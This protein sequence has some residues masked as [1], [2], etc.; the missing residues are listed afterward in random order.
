MEQGSTDMYA[1]FNSKTKKLF[2]PIT[3]LLMFLRIKVESSAH[4][5]SISGFIVNENEKYLIDNSKNRIF[6][7]GK[8]HVLKDKELIKTEF[9]LYLDCRLFGEMFGLHCDFI[10]RSLTVEIKPDFE[11]P[12]IREMRLAQ[13]RQNINDLKGEETVDTTLGRKYHI[14]RFG[15][16]DWAVN[17]TQSSSQ[18]SDTRIWLATGSELLLGEANIMLNYSSRN[19]INSRTQQYYWRWVN[20]QSKTVKEIKLGK[21]N[22]SGIASVYDP[23]VGVSVTNASTTDRLSFGEYTISDHTEPGWIVELYV[24]NV[25]VGFQ[26]AYFSG[27]YSF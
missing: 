23:L 12:V 18:N 26:T 1:L 7:H 3:D 15:M 22:P 24:N 14:S 6:V 13:L 5:D 27:F 8:Y 21:I 16:V 19:G 25:M 11:I 2:L 9:D 4:L 10:F 20:N 17:S